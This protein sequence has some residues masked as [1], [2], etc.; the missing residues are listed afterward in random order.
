M[1]SKISRA[2]FAIKQ[3]KFTMPVEILKT[4]YFALIHPHIAY[5]I[6]AWGMFVHLLSEKLL[7]SR[8]MPFVVLTELLI[9][10]TPIPYSKRLKK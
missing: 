3:L 4:L 2:I 9:I 1:N 5:G 10:V 7:L 6:L 8:N